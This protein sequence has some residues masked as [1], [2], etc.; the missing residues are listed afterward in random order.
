MSLRNIGE[1]LQKK[2]WWKASILLGEERERSSKTAK[3]TT[4]VLELGTS[5]TT[6]Y[7][8]IKCRIGAS[9]EGRCVTRC[10]IPRLYVKTTVL[11]LVGGR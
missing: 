11:A 2:K 1:V 4:R 3:Y 7:L 6:Q 9:Q 8:D 5:G 10:A